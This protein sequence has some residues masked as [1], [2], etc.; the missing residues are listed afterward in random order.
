MRMPG[1]FNPRVAKHI[2]T[3]WSSYVSIVAPCSSPGEISSVSP[4][5]TT[6][7]PHLASPVRSA[8]TRSHSCTRSRLSSMNRIGQLARGAMAIAVMMLSPRSSRRETAPDS[9]SLA[10]NS[11]SICQPD[12]GQRATVTGFP[13]SADKMWPAAQK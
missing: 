4:L 12:P 10:G 9:G 2:A 13:P 7:A 8:S 3:R 11:A 1:T 6:A 5:S